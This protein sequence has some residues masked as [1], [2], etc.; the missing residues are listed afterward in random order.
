VVSSVGA[1]KVHRCGAQSREP[2]DLTVR[3]AGHFQ[4]FLYQGR[5][6]V[7]RTTQTDVGVERRHMTPVAFTR[8]GQ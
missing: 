3:S 4:I 8:A 1:A 5:D 6:A 7:I 2:V